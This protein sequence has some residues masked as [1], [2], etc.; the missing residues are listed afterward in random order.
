MVLPK[1]NAVDIHGYS[2]ILFGLVYFG[3]FKY[4]E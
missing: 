1:N 4:T 3:T 2:F